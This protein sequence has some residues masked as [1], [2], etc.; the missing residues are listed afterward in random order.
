M[1]YG[2]A[3]RSELTPAQ[4]KIVDWLTTEVMP[5]DIPFDIPEKEY[6]D[7][8]SLE[9]AYDMFMPKQRWEVGAELATGPLPAAA[10][11]RA[12]RQLKHVKWLEPD[13]IRFMKKALEGYDPFTHADDVADAGRL[14]EPAQEH[15]LKK[16]MEESVRETRQARI[17]GAEVREALRQKDLVKNIS[18]GGSY[19][20]VP[21]QFDT[22]TGEVVNLPS[23]ADRPSGLS[24]GF[25][26]ELKNS[27][28][29][30]GRGESKYA[31]T[32]IFNETGLPR[33]PMG[34]TAAEPI[35]QSFANRLQHEVDLLKEALNKRVLDTYRAA[36]ST[37]RNAPLP[38]APATVGNV[39]DRP[40][41]P[42]YSWGSENR[43]RAVD[44][45]YKEMKAP[46]RSTEPE[47]I[48]IKRQGDLEKGEPVEYIRTVRG[49]E[50]KNLGTEGPQTIMSGETQVAPDRISP[51]EWQRMSPRE[52]EDQIAI[53]EIQIKKLRE[54]GPRALA[55]EQKYSKD[56]PWGYVKTAQ[57]V[58]GAR[59]MIGNYRALDATTMPHDKAAAIRRELKAT[60]TKYTDAAGVGETTR[61]VGPYDKS[62]VIP[63][64]GQPKSGYIEVTGK[65]GRKALVKMDTQ[66]PGLM[67]NYP[68]QKGLKPRM[69]AQEAVWHGEWD[70]LGNKVYKNMENKIGTN[71]AS[72][73]RGLSDFDLEAMK[74]EVRDRAERELN[75]MWQIRESGVPDH[76]R[77]RIDAEIQK[78][79]N[80]VGWA[81]E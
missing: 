20:E 71:P 57:D 6:Q 35:R 21:R 61:K 2:W 75:D 45:L 19:M 73:K 80:S 14:A 1:P 13:T 49:R 52:L 68:R 12:L 11:I 55:K 63:A 28:I 76:V 74:S 18:P 31:N 42:K 5:E 81:L 17:P 24:Q 47:K 15:I 69:P 25:A 53:R 27:G 41:L 8:S 56:N 60:G 23:I 77:E 7:T 64:S 43:R 62:T 70:E 44:P 79:L 72:Q 50:A 3:L 66:D 67:V 32:D 16:A 29:S 9:G 39:V 34:G 10:A 22:P 78:I 26:H 58:P 59:G 40:P 36:N 46:A 38:K 30:L 65:G 51:R 54:S 48:I 37:A 4:Q 33:L